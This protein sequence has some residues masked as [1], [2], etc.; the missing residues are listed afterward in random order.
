MPINFQFFHCLYS[1]TL[2]NISISDFTTKGSRKFRNSKSCDIH[3]P[4]KI[5]KK[6]FQL[7]GTGFLH[8]TLC[9]R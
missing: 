4:N 1:R 6:I 9:Q 7:L 5:K 3:L 2:R 8:I